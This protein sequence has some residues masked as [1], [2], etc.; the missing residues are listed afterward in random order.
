[1]L[2]ALVKARR[3]KTA[4]ETV[5]SETEVEDRL[6]VCESEVQN[7]L[8]EIGGTTENINTCRNEQSQLDPTPMQNET[9]N[10]YA[11]A[12]SIFMDPASATAFFNAHV[13]DSANY[14]DVAERPFGTGGKGHYEDVRVEETWGGGGGYEDALKSVVEEQMKYALKKESPKVMNP[15]DLYAQPDK[16]KKKWNTQE[17]SQV[18]GSEEEVATPPDDLYAQPDMTKKK[19]KRRQQHL[20]QE[21]EEEKLAPT[22]PL[23]YKK[24][25]KTKLELDE[26][27]EDTP[28]ELPPFP[29]HDIG[30]STP[31]L[32]V[33]L[34]LRTGNND[35]Y[36]VEDRQH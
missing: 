23:P 20:E 34:Q 9:V 7:K 14:S 17:D 15:E 32:E 10:D 11:T 4:K 3:K 21:D 28:N 18:N 35:D 36:A 1:M 6:Y 29:V 33:D 24:H 26:D 8:C 22:A 5:Q 30:N 16:G 2:A 25:I 19:D 27:E 13:Y 12:E 31:K